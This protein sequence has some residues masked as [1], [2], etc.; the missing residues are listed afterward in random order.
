MKQIICIKWGAKYGALDVNRLY[1]GIARNI[2][3]PFRL[4]C[5]TD[6]TA[7]LRAEVDTRPLP[8][9]AYEPPKNTKGKWPKSRLWGDLGDV[10]GVVLFMDLDVV[11][12]D[13]LD[14]FFAFGRPEDVVL[15]RNAT[16]P[17]EK[18]GQTSIYRM[19]VGA[20]KPLQALFAADPQKVAD[21]YRFEQRFVTRN[22]P[23]G[24]TFWPKGWVSHFRWHCVPT[25]PLNYLREPVPP[26]GTKV[27]IFPGATDPK[28][29]LLGRWS[30]HLPLFE[31]PGDHLKAAF[32]GRRTEGALKHLRHFHRRA[33]WIA[34]YWRE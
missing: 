26:K 4:I 15:A 6:D 30:K 32:D 34:E 16:T 20:L 27:V 9:F 1:G 3:P 28:Y 18:L 17:F 14:G 8:D 2:T 19:P 12:T 11:V 21:E 25:F 10:T 22:A 23:G 33:E 5:F 31:G 29:A 24:V 7:G 13:N